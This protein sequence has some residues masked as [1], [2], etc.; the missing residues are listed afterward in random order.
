MGLMIVGFGLKDSIFAVVDIQY[1]EIQRYDGTVIM[2]EGASEKEKGEAFYSLIR[3]KTMW[4]KY[5]NMGN[6]KMFQSMV[7]DEI[8]EKFNLTEESASQ[9]R[10][11]AFSFASNSVKREEQL[12]R[13]LL[14]Y[15]GVK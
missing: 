1:G 6:E 13:D 7:D 15:G 12:K 8:I 11:M 10:M 14:L 5:H 3:A 4:D 2:A 9:V